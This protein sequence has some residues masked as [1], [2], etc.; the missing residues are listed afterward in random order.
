[1]DSS[2][3]I[4]KVLRLFL[5][6]YPKN[7]P[8]HPPALLL[9]VPICCTD[10]LSLIPQTACSSHGHSPCKTYFMSAI[11]SENVSALPLYPV[12]RV[13]SFSHWTVLQTSEMGVRDLSYFP[14]LLPDHAAPRQPSTFCSTEVM[15]SSCTYHCSPSPLSSA[16]SQ[17]WAA[18]SWSFPEPPPSAG[19]LQN[20]CG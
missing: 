15:A 17:T 20:A 12:T 9:L 1:M 3:S 11:S 10:I 19:R 7:K 8:P 13:L 4:M 16:T 5:S 6:L 14:L 18:G 2:L